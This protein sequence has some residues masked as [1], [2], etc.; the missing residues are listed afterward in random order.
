[1]GKEIK[2][3]VR[4]GKLLWSC[5]SHAIKSKAAI[6][7]NR[8]NKYTHVH[9]LIMTVKIMRIRNRLIHAMTGLDV[10][11]TLK[12]MGRRKEDERSCGWKWESAACFDLMRWCWIKGDSASDPVWR[13]DTCYC[14]VIAIRKGGDAVNRLQLFMCC[15]SHYAHYKEGKGDYIKRSYRAKR[16]INSRSIPD[17]GR[18]RACVIIRDHRCGV[19]LRCR[20]W[21]RAINIQS[22]C[23]KCST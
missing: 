13:S 12:R 20:W 1:M 15:N 6:D 16:N 3:N 22:Q 8:F 18:R 9:P 11:I 23:N 19:E 4:S 14:P 2:A 7:E 21:W 5:Q 10:H 17:P